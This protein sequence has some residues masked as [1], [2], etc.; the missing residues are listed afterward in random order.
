[1]YIPPAWLVT[2]NGT[3]LHTFLDAGK[4][5]QTHG[6]LLRPGT[7]IKAESGALGWRGCFASMQ[8][9]SPYEEAFAA[10]PAHLLILHLDGRVKVERWLSGSSLPCRST[11]PRVCTVN[12]WLG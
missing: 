1:M 10:K 11:V 4:Y 8:T 12:I 5:L 6:L 2:E 3:L 7:T 9:E